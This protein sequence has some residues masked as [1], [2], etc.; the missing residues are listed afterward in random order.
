MAS[1]CPQNIY[2]NY[3]PTVSVSYRDAK[4]QG[5]YFFIL[6]CTVK[7]LLHLSLKLVPFDSF[8]AAKDYNFGGQITDVTAVTMS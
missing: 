7:T 5:G 3:S 4:R 2:N 6:V 1:Q 8:I